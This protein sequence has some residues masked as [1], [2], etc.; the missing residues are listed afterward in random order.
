[1]HKSKLLVFIFLNFILFLSIFSVANLNTIFQPTISPRQS[2]DQKNNSYGNQSSIPV[3]DKLSM[4]TSQIEQIL[5][6]EWFRQQGFNGTNF[7]I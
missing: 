4:T 2:T 5:G 7:I 6:L 1:M 3:N